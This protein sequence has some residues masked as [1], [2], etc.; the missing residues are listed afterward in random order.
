[1]SRGLHLKQP[2]GLALA[3]NGD[4]LTTNAGDGNVV[5]TTPAGKQAAIRPLDTK[6]GAGSLFGLTLAGNQIY[7]VDDGNNTVRVLR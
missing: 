6:T 7:Y 5:E 4:I 1:V 3:P 2:L